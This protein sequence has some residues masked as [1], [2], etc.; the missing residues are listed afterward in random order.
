MLNMSQPEFGKF[1]GIDD[2]NIPKYELGKIK[3]MQYNTAEKY[4][5]KIL[6]KLK[7]TN[8][9]N[10]I[11]NFEKFER[12][13]KGWFKIENDDERLLTIRRLGAANT[14]STRLTKQ[15]RELSKLLNK[16]HIQ[17]KINYYFDNKSGII[18][19]CFIQ[20]NNDTI[21]IECKEITSIRRSMLKEEIRRLAYQAYKI[22]FYHKNIKILALI[23][24]KLKLMINN[25]KELQ[26]PFDMV[27]ENKEDLIKYLT[28]R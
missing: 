23:E 12:S 21:I 15:E 22:K 26:G 9:N 4:V 10:V 11:N 1:I 27:F 14:L 24:S 17:H 20:N 6:Q 3:Q 19:D 13:S 5:N 8:V 18:V 16:K 28:E 2:A 25:I 7:N